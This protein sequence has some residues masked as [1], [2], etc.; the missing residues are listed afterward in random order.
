VRAVVP[1]TMPVFVRISATEWME[2]AGEPSWTVEDSIRLA[3]LL[4]ALGIDL[5]DVSSGGNNSKQQ[6]KVSPT[7]QVSIAGRIRAALRADGMEM[8]IGAL[9]MVTTAELARSAVQEDGTLKHPAAGTNGTIEVEEEH[10]QI[11]QGDL[12]L[13]A[14]QF[15][16]EPEFVLRTAQQLGVN[17]HWPHQYSR[18]TWR[19]DAKI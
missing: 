17:V 19:P 9:G 4:P 10:G 7:Y 11:T 14:R 5:L 8:L 12:V 16:R 1:E 13:V 3:K 2:W 15:L 18:A 6:I